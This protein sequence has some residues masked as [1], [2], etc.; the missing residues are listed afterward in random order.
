MRH[1]D[2]DSG[3]DIGSCRLLPHVAAR[4][5]VRRAEL[6]DISFMGAVARWIFLGLADVVDFYLPG[7]RICAALPSGRRHTD[8]DRR[9]R[10]GPAADRVS[11][12][13]YLS[14]YFGDLRLARRHGRNR[15]RVELLRQAQAG[16]DA[17]CGVA[18]RVL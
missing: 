15:R 8:V 17:A 2:C 5:P 10:L 6:A 12:H 13:W 14:E 9:S 1:V 4:L 16:L 11:R 7:A 18:D 3:L